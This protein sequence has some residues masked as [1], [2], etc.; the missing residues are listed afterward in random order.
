M[1][2]RARF[3]HSAYKQDVRAEWRAAAAGWR[4]WYPTLEAE[5]AG[6]V[7]S[8]ALVDRARVGP[9]D[10]VL[11]VAAGYGEPG[12]TAARAVGPRGQVV[13]CDISQP[14]LDF[15]RERAADA[16]IGN[17]AFVVGDVEELDFGGERFD[18]VIS[19]AGIMYFVDVAG[20]LRRLRSS[21]LRPGGRLAATVWSTPDKVDFAAPVPIMRE[22]L[23]LPPPPPGAPGPFALGDAAR[24][25][26]VV[27]EAGFDHVETGAIEVVYELDSPAAATQWLR[28][29]APPIAGLVDGRSPDLQQRV[30]DRV[31]E[32][33]SPYVA[34]N[35]Q[36]RLENEALWVAARNPG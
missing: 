21:W 9:G 36:V 26:T 22:M 17:I 29:V 34:G 13:C 10:R 31:T 20:T 5:H 1:A 11:D 35:G 14:M 4:T 7:A 6:R 12:L 23:E 28:E 27:S 15:A 30:W 8:E 3:D 2:Q 32:A 18:A 25:E 16:G 19:R 24:L 33:W